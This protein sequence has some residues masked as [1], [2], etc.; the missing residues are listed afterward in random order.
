MVRPSLLMLAGAIGTA[1]LHAHHTVQ[2]L[3]GRSEVVLGD[4]FGQEVVCRAAVIPP[5]VPHAVV[6]GTAHGLL[7]HFDPESVAGALLSVVP[8]PRD[9]AAGWVGAAEELGL[10][11][12]STWLCGG[13]AS[14][15]TIAG[16]WFRDVDGADPNRVRDKVGA[17]V[18]ATLA[19]G[20][21]AWLPD[22]TSPPESPDSTGHPATTRLHPAVAQVLRTV[23][24][25]LDNGPIRLRDLA[26]EVHL[27]ESRLTHVFSADLGLPFRAYVRWLR[28][29]RAVE[30]L[31]A[32]HSLTEVAH[33]AGFADSA[34][35]TRVCRRMFGAPPSLFSGIRWDTDLPSGA[36][37]R[38]QASSAARSRS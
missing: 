1:E 38:S 17:W 9:T 8:R 3:V 16:E 24:A 11:T 19:L 34:H 30:L 4:G 27:S 2:V 36:I 12:D 29:Q 7:V 26:R 15:E 31:A 28:V 23:P 21:D 10:D 13:G 33:G 6:R 37:A 35:L 5:N 22:A 25:R 14:S 20:P 32:G 18:R